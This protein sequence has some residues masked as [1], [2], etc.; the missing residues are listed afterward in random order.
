MVR[1]DKQLA[2]VCIAVCR[3]IPEDVELWTLDGPAELAKRWRKRSP[4]S[5]GERVL[6]L[7]AWALWNNST[8]RILFADVVHS[9]SGDNLAFLGGLLVALA[10][11][12]EAIDGWLEILGT[13]HE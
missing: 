6:L 10:G 7:V 12:S 4:L 11:G 3:R 9:L 2:A 1:D 5:S 13:R 8:P